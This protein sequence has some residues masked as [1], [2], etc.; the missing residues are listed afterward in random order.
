[1]EIKSNIDNYIDIN[2]ELEGVSAILESL[3]ENQITNDEYIYKMQK[4]LSLLANKINAIS[5]KVCDVL[6]IAYN[7]ENENTLL[8]EKV[9]SY[10]HTKL[11]KDVFKD[12]FLA[13]LRSPKKEV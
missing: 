13:G 7:L 4:A 8:K 6:D 2:K 3:A 12:S 10:E 1:M 5:D 9:R 11:V